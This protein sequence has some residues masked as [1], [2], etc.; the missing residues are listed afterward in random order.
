MDIFV[1]TCYLLPNFF[2]TGWTLLIL[3]SETDLYSSIDGHFP[4]V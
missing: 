2:L 4:H 1:P 3:H